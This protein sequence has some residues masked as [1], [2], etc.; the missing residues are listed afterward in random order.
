[1]NTK[2]AKIL[3]L[4]AQVCLIIALLPS[5]AW[6]L[7][8]F[9]KNPWLY[10]M[11][12]DDDNV[13]FALSFF[14]LFCIL[15]FASLFIISKQAQSE[16]LLHNFISATITMLL[17]NVFALF[18]LSFGFDIYL[19]GGAFYAQNISQTSTIIGS[20][21][22]ILALLSAIFSLLYYFK[23]YKELAKIS[24]NKLFMLAFVFLGLGVLGLFFFFV[25]VSSE[26]FS[27]G[28]SSEF[29]VFSLGVRKPCAPGFWR[30]PGPCRRRSGISARKAPAPVG[31]PF[32]R[33]GTARPYQTAV[34]LLADL[35]SLP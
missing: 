15:K 13:Y 33:S 27:C 21:L 5:L 24:Q 17:A 35:Q 12:M 23:L 29:P 28:F 1:M 2:N 10:E 26:L 4:G 18:G 22:L 14:V 25:S 32:F 7:L 11:V 16:A 6:F 3:A 9:N 8:L 31:L 20:I 19:L 34:P 30:R